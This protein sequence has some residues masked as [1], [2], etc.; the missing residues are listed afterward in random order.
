LRRTRKAVLFTADLLSA[1]L[2][3][4]AYLEPNRADNISALFSINPVRAE[5]RSAVDQ[6]YD[7]VSI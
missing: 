7:E 5:I 4:S 6:S 3:T 2:L 1:L